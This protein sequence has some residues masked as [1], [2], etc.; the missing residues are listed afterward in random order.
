MK[1]LTYSALDALITVAEKHSPLDALAIHVCFNHALRV[2]ELLALT[3]ANV[4]DTSRMPAA[5]GQQQNNP[6]LAQG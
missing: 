3:R 2:S 6:A 5:Q 4:V 1:S